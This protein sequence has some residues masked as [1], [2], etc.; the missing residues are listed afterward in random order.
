MYSGSIVVNWD[1]I[2]ARQP[3]SP[4]LLLEGERAGCVCLVEESDGE[5]GSRGRGDA[6]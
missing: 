4:M 5:L 6:V 3:P 2:V 1:A